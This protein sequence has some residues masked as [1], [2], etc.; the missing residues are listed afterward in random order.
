M[1]N[2]LNNHRVSGDLSRSLQISGDLREIWM[3]KVFT[4]NLT[5]A[6][7]SP[8]LNTLKTKHGA[9][10]AIPAIPQKWGNDQK[11]CWHLWTWNFIILLSSY[12]IKDISIS[13]ASP[14]FLA[15][16]LVE[17]ADSI[18]L[19]SCTR[20]SIFVELRNSWTSNCQ[21]MPSYAKLC[22]AARICHDHPNININPSQSEVLI[23]CMIPGNSCATTADVMNCWCF[24]ESQHN[25]QS[26]MA[27][28]LL[29]PYNWNISHTV[30]SHASINQLLNH[31][32]YV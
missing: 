4:C 21:A 31:N 32:L 19:I 20:A 22:Q 14:M 29:R 7:N 9:I 5:G 1:L 30:W 12:Q 26:T 17:S 25:A 24:L 11:C 13:D 27:V 6:E 3:L 15:A 23:F 10:P 28:G 16:L 18:F 8:P 2:L